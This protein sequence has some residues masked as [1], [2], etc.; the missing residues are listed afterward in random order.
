[1]IPILI[2]YWFIFPTVCPLKTLSLILLNPK[3]TTLSTKIET[4]KMAS[5]VVKIYF[6]DSEFI[7]LKLRG[8]LVKDNK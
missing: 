4:I 3:K 5:K 8:V 7:I 6:E 1:M 2:K